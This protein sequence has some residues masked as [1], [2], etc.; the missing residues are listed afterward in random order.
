MTGISPVAGRPQSSQFEC[1]SA[2]SAFHVGAPAVRTT[3]S[4]DPKSAHGNLGKGDLAVSGA[5]TVTPFPDSCP[6]GS[7]SIL[8]T[9]W[10]I[11]KDPEVLTKAEKTVC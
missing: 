11:T 9:H 8:R 1:D 5:G 4:A 6:D 7:A 10:A 2:Q 3:T